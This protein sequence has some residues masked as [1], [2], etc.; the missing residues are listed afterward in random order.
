MKKTCFGKLHYFLVL[1]IISFSF[2]SANSQGSLDTANWRFSNPK[3]FGFTVTDL[4]FFDDSKAIAVSSDGG[5]AFTT[6]GGTKWTYGPF[7]FINPAGLRVKPGFLDVHYV[8]SN[9]AYAVG[10]QGCMAKSAD[11]GKTWNFVTTPLFARGRNINTVWFIN[12]DT[13]YIGGQHN[14]ID[15][16]PKLYFT[17]NG[18]ATWD[19][20]YAPL[21]G[22]TA[23]GYV[24]NPNLAPLIWDVDAKEKEIQRIEFLNDSVG[25]ISG[26]GTSLFPTHPAVNTTTCLPSGLTTTTGAQNASLL[27][28]FTKGVLIDYS[29]SKERVGY[30]GIT[31]PVTCSSRFGNVNPQSQ[32]YKAFNIINDSVLVM[33]SYNNNIVVKVFTGKNDSTLNVN[34]P[35]V[36]ER[37]RYQVLNFPFPPNGATPIPAVQVLLASNP[38]QLR[39]AAN[40]KLYAAAN[41]G[42]LWTSVDTGRNWVQEKSLPQNQNYSNFATW[43]LD[44]TPSGKFVSMGQNGVTADSVAGGVWTSNYVTVP[45]G[46]AYT[47]MDFADCNNGMVTGGSAITV[48]TDGGKTWIDRG[49]PDFLSLNISITGFV[50]P[51]V[52]KAYLTTNSGTLYRTVDQ[53]ATL[54]PK[55]SDPSLQL[56]DVATVGTDSV[57]AVAYSAFSVPT[58]SRTSSIVRSFD[59]ATTFQTIGG[60]PVGSTAPNLSKIAFPSKNIGYI[61]GTRNAVYKTVDGGTTWT[62]IN[63]FPSQNEGPTGF[64]NTFL[65]YTELVAVDDNTVFLI[66]N[67]FTSTGIKRVYK[68]IDGGANWTDITSNLPA[69]FP[70]GNL[71]GLSFHDANN[72]YVSA[73]PVLF[74]TNNGGTSWTMDIAPV[75]TIFET[76]AFA[77]KKVPAGISMP[78]RRLFVAGVAPGTS[79][80]IMEYGSLA[81]LNVNTAE[82]IVNATCTNPTGGSITINGTGGLAPYTYSINGG[83]FQA[84]NVFSGL[85]QGVK[86][87]QVKDAFCGTITKTVTVG[88]TDNMVLTASNDTIVCA[89]APVPLSATTNGS[90]AAYVWTPAAGL[91]AANIGN[92]IA[93]I[94]T[95]TAFTVN[96]TLN[97]CVRAK[98]VN[99]GIKLSP[100]VDAGPDKSILVGSSVVLNGTSNGTVQSIAWTPANT[101]SGAN[102]F[103]PM[104]TPQTTT[105]YTMSVK[106]NSNCTSIDSAKVTVIQY[107]VKP[108]EAFTPNGDAMHDKWIVTSGG[109]TDRVNVAVFNRYGNLIYQKDNYTND[110]DGTYNGKPVAD[111]TYY[112]V[113]SFKL[114]N[115]DKVQLTGNVTILR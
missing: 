57:W 29:L 31:N 110:W 69:L 92:P 64:P 61:A 115:G 1:V 58:A 60:F 38:Y 74:N 62:S 25:Y 6:T 79:A 102:T 112:Y 63:P 100:V 105:M 22:K 90:G 107:C 106:D 97:G 35:G 40:G 45:A 10:N 104:A 98:T 41:F 21:G 83:A 16:I 9:V 36:Y 5:I 78:N 99:V 114:I 8:T 72:G 65:A 94:N 30:Q 76:M 67:M 95:A 11:G 50:Y 96:A 49:R 53:A 103:T 20:L 56:N 84:S 3:Q 37:G 68:T 43:A 88:F 17:R 15:S 4:D 26:G 27:W 13:G 93:N 70:V 71:V 19:S 101:L 34:V 89:G 81:N 111:G 48:T 85:G 113:V 80:A 18:G 86:N 108:M 46:A 59:N 55:F 24:N 44:I 42:N 54:D 66:G 73:G 23:V 33:L 75:G 82:T 28:K 87:I 91:S 32:L 109:C 51:Y 77:P 2:F 52:N 7:T 12:K 14:S 39:R 47:D